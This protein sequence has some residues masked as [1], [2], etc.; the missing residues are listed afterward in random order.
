MIYFSIT[1]FFPNLILELSQ[2]S[3]LKKIFEY[4]EVLICN[5]ASGC[6]L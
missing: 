1:R 2:V 5:Y 4:I 6:G 3:P